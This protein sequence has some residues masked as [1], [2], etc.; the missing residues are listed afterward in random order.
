MKQ[1]TDPNNTSWCIEWQRAN[2]S[3]WSRMVDG[4]KRCRV[5]RNEYLA[6]PGVTPKV[7]DMG[8]T[9]MQDAR[10]RFAKAGGDLT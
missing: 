9:L 2:A 10:A 5:T 4:H 6:G 3:G 1:K 7:T 8:D